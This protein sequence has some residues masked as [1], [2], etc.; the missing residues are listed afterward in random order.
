VNVWDCEL[1]CRARMAVGDVS[2]AFQKLLQCG[3][4]TPWPCVRGYW[5]DKTFVIEDGRHEYIASLMLGKEF[6]L[7]AWI[8]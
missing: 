4:G 5:R 2:N 1:A 7:V 3:S 8:D 6:I